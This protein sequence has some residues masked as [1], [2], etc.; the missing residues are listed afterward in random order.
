MQGGYYA[1]A[2]I[3]SSPCSCVIWQMFW[4]KAVKPW[5]YA[6]LGQFRENCR[7]TVDVLDKSGQERG[8]RASGS[9]GQSLLKITIHQTHKLQSNGTYSNLV[10]RSLKTSPENG[11]VPPIFRLVFGQRKIKLLYCKLPF[12]TCHIR[13]FTNRTY[14]IQ[15]TCV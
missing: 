7:I 3:I 2:F 6:G 9:I 11:P 4:P 12:H 13:K 5:R 14:F 1:A 15:G 10:L 8:A